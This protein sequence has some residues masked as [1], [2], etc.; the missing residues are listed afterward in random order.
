MRRKPSHRVLIRLPATLIV[1][2][3]VV[4]AA[5]YVASTA[6]FGA[7][8]TLHDGRVWKGVI[9]REE[10]GKLVLNTVGG[11]VEIARDAIRHIDRR[12]T[13]RQLYQVKLARIDND[14]ADQ[15]YL[16]GLWCGHSQLFREQEYHL[17]YAVGLDPDHAGARRVLGH[18]KY[19]D[20]WMPEAEAKEAQ[21][22]RYYGGRW[23]TKEAAAI[24]ETE[25]LKRDLRKELERQV[26][27]LAEIIASPRSEKAKYRA[28]RQ[29][30][31]MRDPL[32]YDTIVQLM[33]HR[34][35]DVRDIAIRAADKLKLAGADTE[36]LH[37]ALY[38]E[39]AAV[40]DRA[41]KS[42]AGR[43]NDGM[44]PETLRALKHPDK[45]VVRFAAALLLGIVKDPAAID[46]LIDAIYVTYA[47]RR[48]G[49][50]GP[51][52]IGLRGRLQPRRTPPLASG[53]VIYDPVAGVVGAGPGVT[54]RPIDAPDDRYMYLINYAA[55]DALRAITY[56]DFGV[57]KRAW[58]EWWEE[59]RDEF[60][61]WK[62]IK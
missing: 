41:R 26:R 31:T 25:E 50:A 1:A 16:L 47:L 11:E 39:D 51:P 61:V 7:Q 56:K 5:L 35:A 9:V 6:L 14:D 48:S 13:P 18:V 54:W 22:L 37:L 15:H 20:R 40:R 53:G 29:L 4:L 23:M 8:I 24:A 10:P 55:L 46:A 62:E 49:E 38:D 44:L 45:P 2:A 27:A 28:V 59:I 58:R 32:A 19:D 30:Y 34:S 12:P 33:R 43:W 52:V 42:I 3:S 60:H 21:G 17:N 57:N 36:I